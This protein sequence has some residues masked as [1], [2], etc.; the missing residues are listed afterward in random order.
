MM[1]KYLILL[2]VV[3]FSS[4]EKSQDKNDPLLKFY[5][6]AYEDIGYSIAQV[7]NGYLIAGQFTEITRNEN[8]YIEKSIRK[9][10]IILTD[11]EGDRVWKTSP[12]DNF[13]SVGLKV[14]PLDDGSV[15]CTGY[16]IDTLLKKNLFVVKLDANGVVSKQMVFE[17]SG[18]Q[19]G[20]DIIKTV[21]GFMI[22]GTTDVA[23]PASAESLG[24][25]SGKK[26]ILI[27]RVDNNLDWIGE[28]AYGFPGNDEGV[29]IKADRDGGYIVV[30]TTDRSELVNSEQDRN[31][32]FLL[33]INS[34]GGAPDTRI[35][36]GVD[37]EYAADIEVVND[38]YMVAGTIGSEG[39]DQTGYVWK[40]SN[41]I[42][43]P[44]ILKHE[45]SLKTSSG[46]DLNFSVNAIDRY[47]TNSFVMAGQAVTGSSTKMLIFVTDADGYPVEGKE[48]VAGSTGSQ[49]AY[50]VISDDNDNIIAVGKNSYGNNSMI[51][52][53]KFKF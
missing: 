53:L 45:I 52:L 38:G 3:L 48:M 27:L 51:S 50:D 41:D 29:A 32:I 7:D 1:R 17:N 6:D 2:L 5:G 13:P 16:T 36:G 37:D 31:N 21:E 33:K 10:T 12:G 19:Y 23:K 35:F 15:V 24:N 9:M 49:A 40:L 28:F 14:L 4:C 20:R 11:N 18:N 34:V 8:N 44:I 39:S 43:E 46:G 42:S 30:G 25:I 26:D 22:L 47:K